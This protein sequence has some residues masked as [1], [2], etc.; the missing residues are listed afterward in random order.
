LNHNLNFVV[1]ALES[2]INFIRIV[3]LRL[4]MVLKR[5]EA[6]HW[7]VIWSNYMIS[8]KKDFETQ[9]WSQ[10]FQNLK[11]PLRI[12]SCGKKDKEMK[13]IVISLLHSFLCTTSLTCVELSLV[14]RYLLLIISHLLCHALIRLIC[15]NF[16][17]LWLCE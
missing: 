14:L 9:V 6:H 11:C 15:T 2:L 12:Y 13:R 7:L 17:N 8:F 5:V 10:I 1:F 3:A 16:R 4:P